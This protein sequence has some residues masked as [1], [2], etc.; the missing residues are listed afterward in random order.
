MKHAHPVKGLDWEPQSKI[1]IWKMDLCSDLYPLKVK[2]LKC[3][4]VVLPTCLKKR[5]K[6]KLSSSKGIQPWSLPGSSI[7]T[8]PVPWPNASP[9]L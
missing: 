1:H 6:Q 7:E 5:I 2:K 9:R 4:N 3:E 8:L